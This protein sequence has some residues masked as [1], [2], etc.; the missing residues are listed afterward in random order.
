MPISNRPRLGSST[1]RKAPDRVFGLKACLTPNASIYFEGATGKSGGHRSDRSWLVPTVPH[2]ECPSV[3]NGRLESDAKVVTRARCCWTSSLTFLGSAAPASSAEGRRIR[4]L[5]SS[6]RGSIEFFLR[7]TSAEALAEH[8]SRLAPA[9]R[10][11]RQ[12]SMFL[13]RAVSQKTSLSCC[14][15]GRKMSCETYGPVSTPMV[16]R[17][18]RKTAL[19]RFSRRPRARSNC[20]V[21]LGCWRCA[22]SPPMGDVRVV[23][24]RIS[25]RPP[26]DEFNRQQL[27]YFRSREDTP[28]GGRDVNIRTARARISFRPRRH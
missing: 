4:N 6:F 9:A 3:Q 10:C 13:R 11:M 28:G 27:L 18:C 17:R 12:G 7:P 24:G 8:Y 21:V 14:V 20:C 19:V 23:E 5:P 22:R 16:T 26:R 25:W 2:A 1:K 15:S